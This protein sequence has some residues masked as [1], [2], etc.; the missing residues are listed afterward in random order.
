MSF[1]AVNGF[2]VS[3][4]MES[5]TNQQSNMIVDLVTKSQH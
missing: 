5:G 3:A 4:G 2:I 1:I